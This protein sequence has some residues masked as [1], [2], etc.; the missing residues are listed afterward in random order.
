MRSLLLLFCCCCCVCAFTICHSTIYNNYSL[1]CLSSFVAAVCGHCFHANSFPIA[2]LCVCPHHTNDT[3]TLHSF[4]VSQ[5]C[6]YQYEIGFGD[7]GF[8]NVWPCLHISTHM[9]IV[10]VNLIRC[11]H[12]TDEYVK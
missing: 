11:T 1:E 8:F 3:H 7:P 5:S 2:V 9:T 4:S 10:Q 6:F 12:R